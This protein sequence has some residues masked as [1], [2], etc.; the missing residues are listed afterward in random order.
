M[1]ILK[2]TTIKNKMKLLGMCVCVRA[3]VRACVCVCVCV[4]VRCVVCVYASVVASVRE[5][6][7]LNYREHDCT[8]L[9]AHACITIRHC[10]STVKAVCKKFVFYN[11][12]GCI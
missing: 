11:L 2:R 10:A 8:K 5:Y 3:C 12:R 7:R 6:V 1:S 9:V 4:C